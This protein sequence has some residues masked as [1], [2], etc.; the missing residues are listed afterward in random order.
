MINLKF[1]VKSEQS[2]KIGNLNDL[3][4]EGI[5]VGVQGITS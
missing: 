2:G 1:G 4:G 3:L 5:N